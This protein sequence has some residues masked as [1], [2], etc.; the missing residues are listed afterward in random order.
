MRRCTR[1]DQ[2][3][4]LVG[5]TLAV[6]ILADGACYL[7]VNAAF[8]SATLMF[9]WPPIE[10][11]FFCY[12]YSLQALTDS[13]LRCV[14]I[15]SAGAGPLSIDALV[16]LFSSRA[17]WS[18]GLGCIRGT[19][20]MLT[21]LRTLL[22]LY[23]PF[24]LQAYEKWLE[25]LDKGIGETLLD[26]GFFDAGIDD[27]DDYYLDEDD[28]GRG[29]AYG[30]RGQRDARIT[31]AGGGGNFEDRDRVRRRQS[32]RDRGALE[33]WRSRD[34]GSGFDIGTFLRGSAESLVSPAPGMEEQA[35]R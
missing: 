21:S 20:S 32:S 35:A 14:L 26:A 23:R 33:D 24:A 2:L 27:D 28:R 22:V 15:E 16:F 31:D 25:V 12:I 30:Y 13:A 7:H 10:Q 1:Q 17:S 34:G 8:L 29:D 18:Q 9:S 3:V 5:P 19:I 6:T 11:G 4:V